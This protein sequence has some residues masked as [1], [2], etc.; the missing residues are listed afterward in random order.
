[1]GAGETALRAEAQLVEGRELRRLNLN[2]RQAELDLR[3]LANGT[4]LL[5][6][7]SETGNSSKKIIIRR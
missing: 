4:Y 2:S 5:R 6:I 7:Q 3:D 1:M